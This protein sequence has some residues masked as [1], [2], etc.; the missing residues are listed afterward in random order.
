MSSTSMRDQS[1]FL[2][3][4]V[5]VFRPAENKAINQLGMLPENAG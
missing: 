4:T 2:M 5:P 1:E 3:M